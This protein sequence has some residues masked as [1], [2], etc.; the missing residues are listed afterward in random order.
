MTGWAPSC[1]AQPLPRSDRDPFPARPSASW[2]W[3][4]AWPIPPEVRRLSQPRACPC[5][6]GA[7]RFPHRKAQRFPRLPRRSEPR[8][9]PRVRQQTSAGFS[10]CRR[11]GWPVA[12]GATSFAG[13]AGLVL[14]SAAGCVGLVGGAGVVVVIR[15][16]RSW[17]V[18]SSALALG[19]GVGARRGLV[20]KPAW[21]RLGVS[22][23]VGF[24]V[25]LVS[26]SGLASASALGLVSGFLSGF[27][28]GFLSG[29]FTWSFAG[30]FGLDPAF[31]EAS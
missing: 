13:G 30:G 16:R 24:G 18:A 8:A 22:G 17:S 27:L 11:L 14:A 10:V 20:A 1:R 29:V 3:R 28:A 5:P 6:S 4:R 26:A 2:T 7:R 21:R 19:V 25:G 12:S 15:R 31:G 9:W 23:L